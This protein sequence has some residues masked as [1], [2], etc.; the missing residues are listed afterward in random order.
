MPLISFIVP[1]YL[2][3][4]HLPDAIHSIVKYSGASFEIIVVDD[5]S[6]VPIEIK[7]NRVHLE[8][9]GVNKGAGKARNIGL[10][11]AKGKF[12]AFLDSDDVLTPDIA[13]VLDRCHCDQE[14]PDIF[15]SSLIGDK[16]LSE[17]FG[18]LPKYVKFSD[19]FV[20]AKLRHFS[21][22]IY[23]RDFLIAKGIFFPEDTKYGEDTLFL[24]N[25]LASSSSLCLTPSEIYD[26]RRRANSLMGIGPSLEQQYFLIEEFPRRLYRLL[27][28]FPLHASVRLSMSFNYRVPQAARMVKNQL[29]CNVERVISGLRFFGQIGLEND[30]SLRDAASVFWNDPKRKLMDMLAHE[31]D[32]EVIQ[33]WL[34]EYQGN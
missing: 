27:S 21:A 26:Y 10:L 30:Q 4:D 3:H 31:A 9:L 5:G 18:E 7:S 13:Q 22:N 15:V 24:I 25:A 12:V 6:P 29:D 14:N 33:K 32:S 20:L 2:D 8:R 11:K 23:R 19:D 17:K 1:V 34:Y 16:F 28:R